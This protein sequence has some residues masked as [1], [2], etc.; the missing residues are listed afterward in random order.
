MTRLRRHS[1]AAPAMNHRLSIAGA[2]F[3]A[4]RVWCLRG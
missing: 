2:T 3:I 4:T 1:L